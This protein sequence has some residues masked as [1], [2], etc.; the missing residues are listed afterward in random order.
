MF[1]P[2]VGDEGEQQEDDAAGQ[3]E[4]AVAVEVAGPA[5]QRPG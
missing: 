3:Q 5:D 4:V 2:E 1:C